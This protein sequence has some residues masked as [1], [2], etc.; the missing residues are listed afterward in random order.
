V[1]ALSLRGEGSPAGGRCGA[2][3][4]KTHA[5]PVPK[6]TPVNIPEPEG[7][8]ECNSRCSPGACWGGGLAGATPLGSHPGGCSVGGVV[9]GA[10]NWRQRQTDLWDTVR[11]PGK[12]SLFLLT[13]FSS[14]PERGRRG[15]GRG[16]WTRR[17]PGGAFLPPCLACAVSQG[18]AGLGRWRGVASRCPVGAT[19]ASAI[20]QRALELDSLRDRAR[21]QEEHPSLMGSPF[22][23]RLSRMVLENQRKRTLDG[24]LPWVKCPTTPGRTHNRSRSPR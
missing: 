17:G 16:R 21:N 8:T 23:T 7:W 15:H 14:S 18:M 2:S 11:E 1:G 6:G 12:R 4:G 20:D 9:Q 3:G 24:K 10:F 5:T 22:F 13:G 19:P